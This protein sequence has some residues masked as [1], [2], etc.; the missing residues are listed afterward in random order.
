MTLGRQAE[1]FDE[2]GQVSDPVSTPRMDTVLDTRPTPTAS[3]EATPI[4]QT[5]VSVQSRSETTARVVATTR[6]VSPPRVSA[7]ARTG[8]VARGAVA[9]QLVLSQSISS[10]REE[11]RWFSVPQRVLLPRYQLFEGADAVTEDRGCLR[12]GSQSMRTQRG[13]VWFV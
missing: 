11:S 9:R 2:S 5:V 8:T 1:L 6:V 3:P 12:V 4:P 7:V 13:H 10:G